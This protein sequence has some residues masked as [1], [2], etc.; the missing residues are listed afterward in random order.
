MSGKHIQGSKGKSDFT[1]I[2]DGQETKLF[3]EQKVICIY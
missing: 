2:L 3:C 1:V